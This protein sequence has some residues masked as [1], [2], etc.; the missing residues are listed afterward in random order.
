MAMGAFESRTI[1]DSRISGIMSTN[2]VRGF[3]FTEIVEKVV[4][5]SRFPLVKLTKMNVC[6]ELHRL[7]FRPRV[8]KSKPKSLKNGRFLGVFLSRLRA[9]Q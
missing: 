4:E 5:N 9:A 7:W 8:L 2:P 1:L 3:L 6:S